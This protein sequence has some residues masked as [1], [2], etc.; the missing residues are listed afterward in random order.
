MDAD[1][2]ARRLERAKFDEML[3]RDALDNLRHNI[4]SIEVGATPRIPEGA[5]QGWAIGRLVRWPIRV[6]GE[7]VFGVGQ[8]P[9]E[10]MAILR[11]GFANIELLRTGLTAIDAETNAEHAKA[12]RLR[13]ALDDCIKGAKPAPAPPTATVPGTPAP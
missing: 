7:L 3:A 6:F 13:Q 11:K 2:M 8:S 5:E 9:E 10:I 4:E 12:T 1:H